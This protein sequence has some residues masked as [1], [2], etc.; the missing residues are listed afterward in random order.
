M[1]SGIGRYVFRQHEF[2]EKYMA[3]NLWLRAA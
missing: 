1:A 2:S 3:T